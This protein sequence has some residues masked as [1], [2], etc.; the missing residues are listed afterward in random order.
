MAAA[1]LFGVLYWQAGS[2]LPRDWWREADASH[3][4]LLG[5]IALYLAW[6]AGIVEERRPQPVLGT[7]ILGAAVCLRIAGGLAAEIFTLRI[8]MLL[9][10]IA[11]IVFTFGLKQIRHWWLPISLLA[12]ALP[13]PAAVLSS[14]AL[15]LQLRASEIGAALME[16]RY[17]PVHAN[18]NVIQ[19]P[20]RTLFVT[21][22]CSGL[23]SL[24]ALLSLSLLFGG[25]FLRSPW[26]RG[27]LIL[28]AIP[29][30]V[31][32]NGVRIFLTGFFVYFV[33]PAFGDGFLHYTEGWLIFLLAVG[34]LGV[35]GIGLSKL[36]QA[37]RRA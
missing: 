28:F 26:L 29:V 3:G 2:T 8:S 10:A 14:I 18:G 6:R 22:A 13:I 15:P 12:L 33:S 35:V 31:L 17:V 37:M 9:A 23:R 32:L 16:M 20:G 21:E 30:A 27:S 25:L 11:L 4:L 1:V 5:P 7:I 19:V 24:T 36:E 34:I